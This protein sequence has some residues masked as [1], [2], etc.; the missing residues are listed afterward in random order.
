MSHEIEISTNRYI[1]ASNHTDMKRFF[2]VP[3]YK[4]EIEQSLLTTNIKA[5]MRFMPVTT[6]D[7]VPP[8]E[9]VKA[10]LEARSATSNS[11]EA[12]EISEEEYNRLFSK[13]LN[14]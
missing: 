5:D 9:W 3:N 2:V 4:I 12:I 11:Y 6:E 1:F 8:K 13:S 10:E 7:I 14:Q